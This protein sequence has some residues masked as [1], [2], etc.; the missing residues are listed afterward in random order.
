MYDAAHVWTTAASHARYFLAGQGTRVAP[1]GLLPSV[2]NRPA[3]SRVLWTPALRRV[4]HMMSFIAWWR[5]DR[6]WAFYTPIH[7]G[8][9]LTPNYDRHNYVGHT[10][11]VLVSG[12]QR[13][14]QLRC[15]G[16]DRK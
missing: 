4:R 3:G 7:D 11:H 5:N 15:Q 14:G 10:G 9:P 8:L 16:R 6:P 13:H 2:L 1:S 12:P